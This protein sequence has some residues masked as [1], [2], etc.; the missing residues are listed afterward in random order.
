M[1]DT[2]PK[3]RRK[4]WLEKEMDQLEKDVKFVESHPFIYLE[5]H[6][7]RPCPEILAGERTKSFKDKKEPEKKKESEKKDGEKKENEKKDGEKKENEKKENEKKDGEKKE[8][9]KKDETIE[10]NTSE[11]KDDVEENTIS[12]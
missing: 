2:L 11:K 4:M 10:I 8:N 5:R 3:M 6:D 12:N 7:L 9:E 1:S